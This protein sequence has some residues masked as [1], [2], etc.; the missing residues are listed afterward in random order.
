MPPQTRTA[1]T[2]NQVPPAQVGDEDDDDLDG[3]ED[4]AGPGLAPVGPAPTMV[5]P[6][7]PRPTKP[8]RTRTFQDV[9][10]EYDDWSLALRRA[11]A[12]FYSLKTSYDQFMNDQLADAERLARL[13]LFKFSASATGRDTNEVILDLKKVNPQHIQHVMVPL[14]FAQQQ[15]VGVALSELQARLAELIDLHQKSTSSANAG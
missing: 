10:Q 5:A 14:I 15:E 2:A 4:E 8:K 11:L 1:R 6:A 12:G 7:M 9:M 3:D 13:P